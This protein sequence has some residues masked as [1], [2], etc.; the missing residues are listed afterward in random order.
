ME[1]NNL[2]SLPLN[3]FSEIPQPKENALKIV[4]LKKHEGR[5]VGYKL[6]DG[7]ILDKAE[8][9]DLA[10]AGGIQGVGISSRKGQEYLKSLPDNN[11][12]N[13][14]GNLPSVT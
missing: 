2:S 11:E 6:S 9:V 14:L 12:E 3:A 10:K 13:N 1:N 7:N 4:A 8:A 5:V